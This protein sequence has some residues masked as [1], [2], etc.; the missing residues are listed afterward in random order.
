MN[1]Y[2]YIFRLRI[3]QGGV[4][5]ENS[6]EV[7]EFGFEKFLSFFINTIVIILLG[8]YFGIVLQSLV[9]YVTYIVLRVYAGG[10]HA[11]NPLICFVIG[12]VALIPF[13]VAIRF[14]QMWN[15]Q[16]AYYALLIAGSFIIISIAP[17]DHKNKRL[18]GIE[19]KIYENRL[20]QNLAI[21]LL[22]AIFSSVY[23]INSFSIAA[24]CGIIFVAV[25]AA[26]GKMM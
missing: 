16:V 19:K 25:T 5:Q 12:I 7:Y 4:I 8:L 21:V 17:V 15:H 13:L 6:R 10:Y 26:V 9:F 1:R 2:S 22:V 24:L 20:H 11:D 14:Y 23:S 18:D 3:I